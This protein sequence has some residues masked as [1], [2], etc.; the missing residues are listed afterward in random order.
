MSASQQEEIKRQYQFWGERVNDGD[1]TFVMPL[2]RAIKSGKLSAPQA[3]TTQRV[4]R[5]VLI[6]RFTEAFDKASQAR[7]HGGRERRD[8]GRGV[9][10][11]L[12]LE[13]AESANWG[14][15]L[16]ITPEDFGATFDELYEL[17]EHFNVA[18][19]PQFLAMVS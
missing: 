13:L 5:E 15:L 11:M 19:Q 7:H 17:A 16:H 12:G 8:T 6:R 4:I 9:L 1:P 3:G 18:R 14:G 10:C 2:A